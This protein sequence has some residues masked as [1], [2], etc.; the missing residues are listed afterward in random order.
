MSLYGLTVTKMLP[1]FREIKTALK[2]LAGLQD[3]LKNVFNTILNLKLLDYV[4]VED[5]VIGTTDTFVSHKL[6][7]PVIGYI[8]IRRNAG[9]SI[10][11]SVTL[12]KAPSSVIILR[13]SAT[14]T[15]TILFF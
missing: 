7:R 13:S 14:V 15:T 9:T 8:I 1:K 2:D 12:N 11:E 3:S 5:V 6:G 4:I 10:W